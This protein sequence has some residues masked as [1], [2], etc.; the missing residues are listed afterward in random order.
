MRCLEALGGERSSVPGLR[1]IVVDG[2]SKDNSADQ[3]AQAIRDPRYSDWVD[4]IPLP[5]NGGFGWA[6]NQAILKL[7]AAKE[8]PEFVHFLNPDTE[9]AKGA[10][11]ALLTELENHPRCGAAG[12]QLVGF[13]GTPA[14][15]AFPF[16]SA[17]HEFVNA[18]L[19]ETV[20][21]LIGI[22]P[23]TIQTPTSS[24]VD[25]VSGA[26][27]MM[28]S[29]ALREVGLFDDG[30]FL[31]F[32]EVE[33]MH[34]MKA[35]GWTVRHVPASRVMHTEGSST[36]VDGVSARAHPAYWYQSRRRYFVRSGGVAGLVRANGAWLAGSIVA[37]LKRLSGRAA[38][39][40]TRTA[41]VLGAGLLPRSSD[42][43]P[44]IPAWGDAPG[45][46]PAWMKK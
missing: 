1:A 21:G 17:G 22:G 23:R 12:S 5:I 38:A 14:A 42:L 30:F 8:P 16:P 32:E 4:F 46:P 20:G 35:A 40:P 6:N 7:A 29:A 25:W 28:R 36:G 41:G 15:S 43:R 33:L 3:L 10:V 9:V 2:G 13:D 27:V 18:S 19:S 39:N 34:R 24:E 11:A 31:Y 26:S 45:R 37:A 44:S